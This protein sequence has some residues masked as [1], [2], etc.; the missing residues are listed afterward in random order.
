VTAK[1]PRFDIDHQAK[2]KLVVSVPLELFNEM[3]AWCCLHGITLTAFVRQ[4][5]AEKLEATHEQNGTIRPPV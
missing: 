2:A 3:Q 1:R 5:S 4:A